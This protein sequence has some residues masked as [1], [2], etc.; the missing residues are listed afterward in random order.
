MCI[1][2]YLVASDGGRKGRGSFVGV[3]MIGFESQGVPSGFLPVA[4]VFPVLRV[5]PCLV[6]KAETMLFSVWRVWMFDAMM[7]V[8]SQKP[9]ELMYDSPRE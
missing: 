3:H 9:W 1:P 2:R 4:I 5:N 6:M 8:S 7:W